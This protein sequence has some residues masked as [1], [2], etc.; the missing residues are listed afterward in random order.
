[1]IRVT[2]N[3]EF[4]TVSVKV[5][6]LLDNWEVILSSEDI[7]EEVDGMSEFE[8][9]DASWEPS[10]N[11]FQ[12]IFTHHFVVSSSRHRH[13]EDS[14]KQRLAT[15]LKEKYESIFNATFMSV[16]VLTMKDI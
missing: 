14:P 15:L 10:K 2:D 3:R 8:Y 9:E 11:G 1:M 6:V 4:K 16:E 13:P 5:D 7:V 12:A